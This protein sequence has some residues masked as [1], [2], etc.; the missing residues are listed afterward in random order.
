MAVCLLTTLLAGPTLDALICKDDASAPAAAT[1][2]DVAVAHAD[3]GLTPDLG[4]GGCPHGHCHHGVAFALASAETA[5]APTPREA[6]L[7]PPLLTQLASRSPKGIE[8]PP[9]A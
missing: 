2:G 4:S 5:I 8:R 1:L 6:L 3:D 9:R 7:A